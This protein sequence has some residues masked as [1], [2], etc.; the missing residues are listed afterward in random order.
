MSL[1]RISVKHLRVGMFLQ[2]PCGSWMDHPFWR[3]KFRIDDP[4]DIAVL[5]SSSVTEV[6][7]DTSRGLDIDDSAQ[8]T[9]RAEAVAEAEQV[10]LDAVKPTVEMVDIAREMERAASICSEAKQAVTSMFSEA[11]MGKALD[12]ADAMPLVE[13]ISNSV[14]RNPGALISLARLKT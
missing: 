3:T 14:L 4:Q 6:W 11:R 9:G 13:E 12:T 8:A 1:K 7:I 2:E 10:L 5:Q